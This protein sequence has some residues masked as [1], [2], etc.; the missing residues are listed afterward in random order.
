M[1]LRAWG[2][3]RP[4]QGAGEPRQRLLPRRCEHRARAGRLRTG[5]V[6]GPLPL[7]PVPTAAFWP[8]RN[9]CR[10]AAPQGARTH[11]A[12]VQCSPLQK[13]DAAQRGGQTHT[14]APRRAARRGV[15]SICPS[16]PAPEQ[17]RW[18]DA[19]GPCLGRCPATGTALGSGPG[20]CA[21]SS[22]SAR[23]CSGDRQLIRRSQPL[24]RIRASASER[25][26]LGWRPHFITRWVEMFQAL[27]DKSRQE[28]SLEPSEVEEVT[29]SLR[30]SRLSGR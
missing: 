1:A 19:C 25:N 12:R 10:G 29:S 23:S 30:L 7:C 15:G 22:V 3:P 2:S 27:L 8:L 6:S 18:G 21:S 26:L 11:P 16:P 9:H 28:R 17:G 20:L 24:L 4:R 5:F 14:W 13:A